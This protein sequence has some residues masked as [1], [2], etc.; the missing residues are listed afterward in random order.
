MKRY[1]YN[2][3]VHG[4]VEHKRDY[5]LSTPITFALLLL[6]SFLLGSAITLISVICSMASMWI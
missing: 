5:T 3:L 4:M 2:P 6:L 1:K